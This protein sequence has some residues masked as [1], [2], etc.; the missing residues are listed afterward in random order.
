MRRARVAE[1]GGL[2]TVSQ[3]GVLGRCSRGFVLLGSYGLRNSRKRK[4]LEAV[5]RPKVPSDSDWV[6]GCTRDLVLVGIWGL[7]YRSVR[8]QRLLTGQC[9][10]A[11]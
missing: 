4:S 9:W 11:A 5:G 7:A 3:G 6:C 1:S 8:G 2:R 10:T